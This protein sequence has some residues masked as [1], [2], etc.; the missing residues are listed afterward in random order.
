M[1]KFGFRLESLVK[2][3]QYQELQAQQDVARAYRDVR[4]CEKRIQTLE[5]EHAQT[6]QILDRAVIGGIRA[7]DFKIYSDYLD[8]LV[9]A[10]GQQRQLQA[11][12]EL[13]L[14]EK[15][16]LLTQR[17]VDRQVLERLKTRKRNEYLQD[18]LRAEQNASD[19]IAS[20]KKAREITHGIH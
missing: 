4:E 10:L 7:N 12:L 18:F 15:Q 20:L 13:T 16:A 6:A 14:R 11:A 19:E 5:H 8:G 1:K 2:Y 9:D 17:S 3:R